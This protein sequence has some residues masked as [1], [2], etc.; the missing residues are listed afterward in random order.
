LDPALR[1]NRWALKSFQGDCDFTTTTELMLHISRTRGLWHYLPRYCISLGR[2]PAAESGQAHLVP[3]AEPFEAMQLLKVQ[4]KAPKIFTN[5][6]SLPSF[7]SMIQSPSTPFVP[8]YP[9]HPNNSS[10]RGSHHLPAY[11]LGKP[12]RARYHYRLDEKGKRNHS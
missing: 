9:T 11:L 7:I 5:P 4:R 6:Q 10:A 12:N 2:S 1:R 8:P 3:R